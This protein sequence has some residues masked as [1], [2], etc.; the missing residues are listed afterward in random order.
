MKS[1]SSVSGLEIGAT[2]AI[3]LR[4][5]RFR[6]PHGRSPGNRDRTTA[7]RV[8]AWC[9]QKFRR[10]TEVS[11]RACVVPSV[12]SPLVGLAAREN[13]RTVNSTTH[14]IDDIDRKTGC[15]IPLRDAPRPFRVRFSRAL[16]ILRMQGKAQG[17]LCAP[18]LRGF[19]VASHPQRPLTLRWSR[20]RQDIHRP[21]CSK[22]LE[23]AWR[24][25]G[26]SARNSAIRRFL[27]HSGS[28]NSILWCWA[29]CT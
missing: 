28:S 15:Q 22:T 9:R 26:S 13:G 2:S 6:A 24:P 23:L 11:R 19:P 8:S 21:L 10:E 3:R 27:A 20:R 17:L 14:Q 7:V 5:E 16:E 25:T 18:V 12:T 4:R 29:P 1:G